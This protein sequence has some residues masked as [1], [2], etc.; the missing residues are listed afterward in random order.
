MFFTKSL[1]HPLPR[2]WDNPIMNLHSNLEFQQFCHKYKIL[3]KKENSIT[4][5]H[6]IIKNKKIMITSN[7]H[8]KFQEKCQRASIV[9]CEVLT[10]DHNIC[11]DVIYL[12]QTSFNLYW[13]PQGSIGRQH[14][15]W[16]AH[17]YHTNGAKSTMHFVL[18]LLTN[19]THECHIRFRQMQKSATMELKIC[20]WGSFY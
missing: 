18:Q 5:M 20:S 14:S 17:N 19:V 2:P 7:I 15:I 12:I 13:L 6:N 9:T 4:P 8:N 1:I 3:D 11:N 10:N 16:F